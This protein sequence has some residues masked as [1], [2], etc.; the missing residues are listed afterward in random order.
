MDRLASI[1]AFIG[2]VENGGFAAAARHLNVSRT[3]VS[4]HVQDLEDRLGVRLLNRTTRRVSLT[5]IGRQYY[6]RSTHFLAEIDEADSEAGALQASPRGLLRVHCQFAR[7]LPGRR[8]RPTSQWHLDEMAVRIAGW[9]FCGA[10]LTAKRGSR[11]TGAT[12]ARQGCNRETD[13]QAA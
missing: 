7:E 8:P 10:P 4:N 5:E 11:P 1:S 13:A 6:E 3:M 12:T 9:Q 2:V